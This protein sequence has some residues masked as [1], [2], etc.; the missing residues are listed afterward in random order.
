M[1]YDDMLEQVDALAVGLTKA[2]RGF[3]DVL[4]DSLGRLTPDYQGEIQRLYDHY[5]KPYGYNQPPEG[6]G[7]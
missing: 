6:S 5:V 4:M 2:E 3:V 7:P 1:D